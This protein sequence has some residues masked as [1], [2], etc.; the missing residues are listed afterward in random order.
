V[1]ETKPPKNPTKTKDL[2]PFHLSR[3]Y[4]IKSITEIIITT[5]HISFG[6]KAPKGP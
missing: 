2:V 1:L 4:P 3:K 5:F 6:L